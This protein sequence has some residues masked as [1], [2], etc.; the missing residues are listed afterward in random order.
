MLDGSGLP[1]LMPMT[2]DNDIQSTQSSITVRMNNKLLTPFMQNTMETTSGVAS[3]D[4]TRTTTGIPSTDFFT[5]DKILTQA[6]NEDLRST[7]TLDNIFA[8]S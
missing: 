3:D 8:T 6:G 1:E 5:G 7:I 4:T 2:S